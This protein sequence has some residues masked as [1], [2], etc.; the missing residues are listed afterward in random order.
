M[1]AQILVECCF[2]STETIGLLGTGTQDG[3]LDFHTAPKPYDQIETNGAYVWD[4]VRQSFHILIHDCFFPVSCVLTSGSASW[5]E[6]A[7]LFF[8]LCLC[9]VGLHTCR[10]VSPQRPQVF[11]SLSDGTT[12]WA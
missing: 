5:K 2:T 9:R 10:S 7:V 8:T 4:G 1:R 12:E 3:H 6:R 11:Q